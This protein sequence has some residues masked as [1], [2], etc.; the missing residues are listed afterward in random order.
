M[1]GRRMRNWRSFGVD[2]DTDDLPDLVAHAVGQVRTL[3]PK[4]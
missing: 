4:D 3:P 2:A 1:P